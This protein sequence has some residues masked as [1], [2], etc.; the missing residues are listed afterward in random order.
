MRTRN[1]EAAHAFLLTRLVIVFLGAAM[2]IVPTMLARWNVSPRR[3]TQ[4]FP[5]RQCP[6]SVCF[7]ISMLWSKQLFGEGINVL[8][9]GAHVLTV[10]PQP[11]HRISLA[12][13]RIFISRTT[14][15][16]SPR[17]SL[18]QNIVKL[19]DFGVPIE[20]LV[21]RPCLGGRSLMISGA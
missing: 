2:S 10:I 16:G 8:V 21:H 11:N 15:L 18:L 17:V 19:L 3:V 4:P 13:H 14:N 5:I 6:T 1:H 20:E 7:R 9:A 12:L